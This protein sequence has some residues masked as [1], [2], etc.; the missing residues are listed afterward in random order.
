MVDYLT[1]SIT[2]MTEILGLIAN[3]EKQKK[4]REKSNCYVYN[5]SGS[6]YEF[7]KHT[8]RSYYILNGIAYLQWLQKE[9]ILKRIWI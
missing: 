4:K 5:K 6:Y 1:T 7:N 8:W 2:S 3:T 9:I